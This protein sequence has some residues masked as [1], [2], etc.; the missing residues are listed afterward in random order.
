MMADLKLFIFR[1]H[2]NFIGTTITPLQYAW[3]CMLYL[4]HYDFSPTSFTHEIIH[5]HQKLSRRGCTLVKPTE[6]KG[7]V[8][9]VHAIKAYEEME[10]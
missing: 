6:S 7:K 2:T 9:P 10:V 1:S 8:V 3:F 5:Q 4:L